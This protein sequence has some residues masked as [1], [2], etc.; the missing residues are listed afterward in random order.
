G[1]GTINLGAGASDTINITSTSADL[2]TLGATDASIQGVEFISASTAAAGVTITLSG[3]TEGFNVTGSAQVD[4]ITGGSG[5]DTIDGGASGDTITG[6][7]GSDTLTGGDGND[8]IYAFN[9]TSRSNAIGA[10]LSSTP[11]TLINEAFGANTGV[12]TYADGGFGGSDPANVTVTGSRETAD[13]RL[14]N[15]SLEV[16]ILNTGGAFTNASGNWSTTVN[17]AQALTN[18]QITFSYR[19]IQDAINDNGENSRVWFEFDG[20]TYD[21]G[22]GNSYISQ[23]TGA[24]GNGGG[25]DDTGWITVTINLPD[26]AAATDYVVR[27]GGIHLGSNSAG[28]DAIMRFDDITMTG[29]A[30]G[31]QV[32]GYS[33]TDGDVNSTN[34]IYG[35]NGNDTIYGSSGNDTL[36]GGSG[37]DNIYSGSVDTT[38][39]LIN[40][41]INANVH[42]NTATGNFYQVVTGTLTWTAAQTAAGAATLNGVAGHLATI[43]S[44]SELSFI[45]AYTGGQNAWLGGSDAGT[46]GQWRWVAGT[47]ENGAQF[48][49]ASGGAVN[50]WY[51]NW[52][53]GQPNDADGTQDYLYLLNGT[54]F[55]DLV[56]QG[57]GSTGYVTIPRYVIEWEGSQVFASLNKNILDGGTGSDSLYG[58]DGIDVFVINDT[59]SVDTIYNF[60]KLGRDKLDLSSLLSGYDPLTHDIANFVQLNV[61]GGNT[62]VA[63]DANG[64]TGGASF[65]NVAILNGVTGLNIHEMLTG[66]NLIV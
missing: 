63:I 11:I 53:A 14:A 44:A 23:I 54:Q 42:Y 2:N 13:G 34:V 10:T 49:N 21:A 27:L 3:Q 56:V 1:T 64:L 43:T 6:G 52:S 29:T 65:T 47:Y 50:G 55:A 48:A 19:H 32:A 51:N 37:T 61:S 60:N 20:T 39:A 26:I 18:V 5:A 36:Y 17:N 58:S 9:N 28:E 12:F 57:N 16:E 30:V 46:E 8:T 62:T 15:G 66:D 31:T 25:D 38:T 24:N 7:A 22:G 59:A 41:L 4:V 33:T 35:G 40:S 45:T